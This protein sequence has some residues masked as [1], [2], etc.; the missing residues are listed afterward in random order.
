M[1]LLYLEELKKIIKFNSDFEF[2][3]FIFEKPNVNKV[4][5]KNITKDGIHMIIGL[6]LN[7]EAQLFLRNQIISKITDIWDLPLI[8]D[9]DSVL[10]EGISKGSTNWQLFGSQKPGNEKYQLTQYYNIRFDSDDG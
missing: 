1:S 3:V 5:E 4:V 7:R 2:P 9:Y 10:D 8:N 6:N